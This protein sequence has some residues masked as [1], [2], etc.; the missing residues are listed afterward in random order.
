MQKQ[1]KL[2]TETDLKMMRAAEDSLL[3]GKNRVEEL[4]LFAQKQGVKRIGI[5]HCIGMTREALQLKDR[6][7]DQFDVYTVDCKYGKVPAAVML[8]D[9]SERGTSCNPAGQADFLAQQQ[10]ELN[11]SFGLCVG[12]DIV[13]NMKSKAP[14]TTLV[15][16][17][18]EH[19]NNP[20]QEF[21]N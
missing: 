12:H 17:D 9:E 7:S 3:M 21:I 4:K 13:F 1:K 15:V 10:T 5:A 8:D 11:I 18:R 14:T 2:Y 19:K 16:K 6:L 20:Y